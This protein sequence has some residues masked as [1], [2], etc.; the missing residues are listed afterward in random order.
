MAATQREA[1]AALGITE[2]RLRQ[3]ISEE[4]AP[5]KQADGTY[6]VDA[7]RTWRANVLRDRQSKAEAD[8]TETGRQLKEEKL[9]QERL[10]TARLQTEFQAKLGQLLPRRDY[11]LFL[12]IALSGL[13]DWIDQLPDLIG[14]VC[15][16]RCRSSVPARLKT[17]LDRR[18][19]DLADELTRGPANQ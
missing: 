1:A 16:E 11:E 14:G 13:S 2:R 12:S 19:H 6:D 5:G 18:R 7:L 9:K 4:G 15:C 8:G 17:E 3:W 10:K